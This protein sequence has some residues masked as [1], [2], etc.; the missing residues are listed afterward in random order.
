MRLHFLCN[1]SPFIASQNV[2]YLILFTANSDSG[3][4]DI[5][6]SSIHINRFLSAQLKNT[7]GF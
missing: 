4:I 7:N 1:L 3:C 5:A 2:V 6:I